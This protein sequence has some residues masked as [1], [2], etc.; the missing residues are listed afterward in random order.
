MAGLVT[1]PVWAGSLVSGKMGGDH[2][3]CVSHYIGLGLARP[4]HLQRHSIC[5]AQPRHLVAAAGLTLL[6]STPWGP[7]L[8]SPLGSLACLGDMGAVIIPTSQMRNSL[9]TGSYHC[10]TKAPFYPLPPGLLRSLY[11]L[12]VQQNLQPCWQVTVQAP[13]KQWLLSVLSQQQLPVTR[14]CTLDKGQKR[15]SSSWSRS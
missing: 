13:P 2:T 12:L 7:S 1:G 9:A 6:R 14:A 4:P 10:H 8:V 3:L 11:L 15:Q 5:V